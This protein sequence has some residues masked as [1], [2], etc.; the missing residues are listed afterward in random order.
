MAPEQLE[1]GRKIDRRADVY[2][3]GVVLYEL[4]CGQLPF[5]GET[6]DELVDQVLTVDP[7][8][9]MEVDPSV[10][11]PLQAIAL[12]AME[13]HP[14]N[15]Y[16]SAADLAADLR[17]FLAGQPVLARPTAYQSS[18]GQRIRP[19]LEHIR[20]WL[21]LKLI[22]AHE[23]EHLRAAYRRLE[24]REDDWILHGRALSW[25]QI[26]LYLGAFL[27][28]FGS[29]LFFA[30]YTLE[31]VQGLVRPLLTLGLPVAGL[32]AVGF[33]LI[34]RDRR[35]VAVAFLLAGA[36]L[37][38]LLV[39]MLVREAGLFQAGSQAAH[40]LFEDAWISNRQLQLAFAIATAWSFVLVRKTR[41][42]ALS[43]AF[44]SLVLLLHLAVLSDF[45]L[46]AWLEDG[47]WHHLAT[48]LTPLLLVYLAFA[49]A[50]ERRKRAWFAEPQFFLAAGLSVVV[51]ELWALNGRL[52]ELV[53][54]STAPLQPATVSDPLLLD[55]ILAMVFNGLVVYGVGWLAD[56][57]GSPLMHGP[58]A[59]LFLIS[60]FAVLEPI[61]YLNA[62]AEYSVRFCWVYLALALLVTMLSHV[63]QRKSFYVAG[64]L[65]TGTA[66][67]QI[68]SRKEWFD[69]PA[70]ATVVL[71]VG[72]AVLATGWMLDRREHTRRKE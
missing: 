57:H 4:A 24:G 10:P 5:H 64:L 6:V 48:G 23:A 9:P 30:S 56:R 59:M 3:L 66:L 58:A 1:P 2:A 68:T 46:R 69:S 19:H 62:T 17:R 26:T 70:W 43:V 21:R 53:G 20:E 47:R 18:L 44:A 8:L 11:E 40:Q 71:G 54:F 29:V 38:P 33:V 36:L 35:A 14:H 39:L 34:A 45:G 32:S 37:V 15:R 16:R 13:R 41:T 50:A 51:L 42:V 67:W 72:L 49:V 27:L 55:T 7:P 61:F 65:N 22:Y 28:V 60:P 52:L 63:R 25:P 12:K 31:A